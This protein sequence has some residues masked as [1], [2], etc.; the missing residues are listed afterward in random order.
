MTD[1]AEIAPLLSYLSESERREVYSL[2]SLGVWRPLPGPQTLAYHSTADTIGFGGAAGGGKTDL[3]IGKALTQHR[4]VAIFRREA[5]QLMGIIDRMIEI[6]G[7]QEGL[8]RGGEKVW[9][10]PVPG[11]QVEFGST[12][13]PGD[14]RKHQGRPKDLLVIDEATNF[15]ESQVRFLM[16]WVRTTTP[17]QR[18][19]TLLTFNPPTDA[20][21]RW[22]EKFFAPWLDPKY[23]IPADPGELRW[24]A[25]IDG[26]DVERVDGAPFTHN[27]ELITPQSRTFIP[28]R[29][30]DNPYLVGTNYMAQLQAMPEPLRSQMLYGDF[31]AGRED[32][33]MQVIPTAW[34]EEAQER[35]QKLHRK[36]RMD[37]VGVDVARGGRDNTIIARRHGMWFDEP[38]VYPGKSTP[39][40]PT[41]AG[42]VIA[43]V[44]DNAPTHIDVVGV[45][46][47]PYDFLMQA[48]QDVY[49]VNGAERTDATDR[50]GRLRFANVR[51]MHW[52]RMRE[53]LEPRANTGIAL[54]PDRQLLIDLCAPVWEL[55]S[56]AIQVESREDI[57][58][59]IGRSPDWASAYLLALI[60]TPR[61]ADLPGALISPAAGHDPYA[62]LG[63]LQ[64]SHNPYA[65]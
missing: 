2:L 28:S 24:F 61:R 8:A 7:H 14:E 44:R 17:G 9:R 55:K 51:S 31:S 22:V 4:R 52:W 19:Q 58:K 64:R 62:V 54:P 46:A 42:V 35:W 18:T 38:L 11:V 12:P 37:S 20:E 34:V 48:R 32:A 10:N 30:T 16:G 60:E 27:G 23:P 1:P 45:G 43:A 25:V 63:E 36:P 59:R 13:N 53:A 5:T 47:S 41:V 57:I 50:S 26:N 33:A 65:R 15:L 6:L 29:V 3:A 40:G 56:G 39:D 21:G 49:G